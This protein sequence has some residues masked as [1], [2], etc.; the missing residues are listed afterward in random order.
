MLYDDAQLTW[1]DSG[2]WPSTAYINNL[3]YT[4]NN[5]SITAGDHLVQT[6]IWVSGGTHTATMTINNCTIQVGCTNI[7][8]LTFSDAAGY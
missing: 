3:S 4:S 5:F 6:T 8:A 1:S 2:S 7:A